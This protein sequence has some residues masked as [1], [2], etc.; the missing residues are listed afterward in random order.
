MQ[1][2][3]C[4]YLINGYKGNLILYT[5]VIINPIAYICFVSILIKTRK[6]CHK[7]VHT[8]KKHMFLRL[9]GGCILFLDLAWQTNFRK[10]P[11]LWRLGGD[12]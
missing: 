1:E 2:I 3:H 11:R 7:S 8:H 6:L 12:L 9:S 10:L 5:I 4:T